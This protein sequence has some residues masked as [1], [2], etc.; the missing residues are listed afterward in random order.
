MQTSATLAA[1]TP[2]LLWMV[3]SD[4]FA[5]TLRG[6]VRSA[7]VH[8][9]LHHLAGIGEPPPADLSTGPVDIPVQSVDDSSAGTSR[10][11]GAVVPKRHARRA[12]TRSL[13][14]RQ[15]RDAAHRHAMRLASGR[16]V[17]RLRAPFDR[18]QFHSAAST[19]LKRA[20]RAELEVLFGQDALLR[21]RRAGSHADP[22]NPGDRA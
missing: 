15:I 17:V 2:V 8:F 16:W 20:A 11:L 4:D 5:R 6:P 9:A 14:K 7:T 12:V 22:T 18:A 10:V 13:I 21:S 3:R 1:P 19:A